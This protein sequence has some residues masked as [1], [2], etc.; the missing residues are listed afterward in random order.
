MTGTV[1]AR[2]LLVDDTD[3]QLDPAERLEAH[4]RGLLHRAASVFVFN[5]AGELLLQRRASSKAAF[6]GKWANTCCTHARPGEAIVETGERR[7][8]E[9]MGLEVALTHVGSFIYVAR[10]PVS[11]LIEHEFDHVLVGVTDVEPILDLAEADETRWVDLDVLRRSV[12][13]PE[14]APWL[15]HALRS[16]P[17]LDPALPEDWN[18]TH[19]QRHGGA[20]DQ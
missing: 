14:Y 11:R 16:F 7:L 12:D 1:L 2:V 17:D 8:R 9:E 5:G 18:R 10:D 6:S 19:D 4:R 13:D 3:S 15:G 20:G